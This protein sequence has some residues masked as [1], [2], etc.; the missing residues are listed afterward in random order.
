[1]NNALLLLLLLVVC[2][3]KD[4]G[5]ESNDD[6]PAVVG[7]LLAISAY[8][9]EFT[10]GMARCHVTIRNNGN[11]TS[12]GLSFT[13]DFEIIGDP[14]DYVAGV[15][16]FAPLLPGESRTGVYV[17]PLS[18]SGDYKHTFVYY[19]GAGVYPGAQITYVRVFTYAG[20][21]SG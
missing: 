15:D 8:T 21:A 7:L 19:N 1:M 16:L 11:E 6:A 17:F 13:S 2:S 10:G 4:G 9:V 12:P 5:D 18:V 14:T 20:S 3:C